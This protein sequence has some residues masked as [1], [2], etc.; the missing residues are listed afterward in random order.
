MVCGF[1]GRDNSKDRVKYNNWACTDSNLK[2]IL[3]TN[4]YFKNNR[5]GHNEIAVASRSKKVEQL[6]VEFDQI[7]EKA[8]YN[9]AI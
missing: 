5:L 8:V 4:S 6:S 1:Q 7:Y 2:L 3:L 9:L